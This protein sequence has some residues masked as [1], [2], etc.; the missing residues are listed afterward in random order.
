MNTT[1]DMVYKCMH[2]EILAHSA[3]Y[4]LYEDRYRA[5]SPGSVVGIGAV[6]FFSRPNSTEYDDLDAAHRANMFDVGLVLSPL[7]HGDYPE[8]VRRTLLASKGA[9]W[10]PEFTDEQKRS[11]PGTLDFVGLNAYF[12]ATVASPSKGKVPG[13]GGAAASWNK[14]DANVTVVGRPAGA[15]GGFG[16]V[17]ATVSPWIIRDV[18]LFIQSHFPAVKIFVTENGL[19][20]K[21]NSTDDWDSRAVYHSAYLRELTRTINEDGADVIGYTVWSFL[22]DFEWGG[23]YERRFGVVHVDYEGGTLN[24]TLKR[25]KYFFQKLMADRAVP[26]VEASAASAATATLAIV[27]AAAATLLR[28][29]FLV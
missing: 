18:T 3:A 10:L 11:L 26:L 20:H 27:L 16:D 2:H 21:E 17:F 4:R 23:G 19:G 25:S 14:V 5:A 1:D 28:A 12:G 8:V 13:R 15:A 22:D 29:P 7:V 9:G 24:R 6:T